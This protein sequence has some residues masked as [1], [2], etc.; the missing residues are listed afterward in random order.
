MGVHPR[1][2]HLQALDNDEWIEVDS[3]R[4]ALDLV[5]P[6]AEGKGES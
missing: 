1:Q 4:T 2:I 5:Q 3:E 6:A